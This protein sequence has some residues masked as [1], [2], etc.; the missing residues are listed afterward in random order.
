MVQ[1]NPSIIRIKK[2]GETGSPCIMMREGLKVSK[3]DPLTKIEKKAEESRDM[4]HWVQWNMKSNAKRVVS[5]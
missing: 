5:M 4:T 3:G 2:K 1:P